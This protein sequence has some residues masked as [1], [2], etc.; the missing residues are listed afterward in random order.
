MS[1]ATCCGLRRTPRTA[2]CVRVQRVEQHPLQHTT[3]RVQPGQTGPDGRRATVEG[4]PSPGADVAAVSP[5]PVQVAQV[6]AKSHCRFGRAKFAIS[7]WPSWR[8]TCAELMNSYL[9]TW[10]TQRLFACKSNLG[11]IAHNRHT[12]YPRHHA[13]R[14]GATIQCSTGLRPTLSCALH[15]RARFL[16]APIQLSLSRVEQRRTLVKVLQLQR[17]CL[18]PVSVQMC[19]GLAQARV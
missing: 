6:S 11:S 13:M 18:R 12:R 19:E 10:P 4:E 17:E 14:S 5:V 3:R 8:A 9:C 2:A 1:H 16:H 7:G 15:T